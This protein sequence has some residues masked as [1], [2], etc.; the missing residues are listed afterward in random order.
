MD[1]DTIDINKIAPRDAKGRL[2]PGAQLG[3][4]PKKTELVQLKSI[5]DNLFKIGPKAINQL[6]ELLSHKNPNIQLGACKLVLQHLLPQ[7]VF[8]MSWKKII[9]EDSNTDTDIKR[10]M[11]LVQ[12]FLQFK[13]ARDVQEYEDSHKIVDIE[14]V[15]GNNLKTKSGNGGIKQIH[16]KEDQ[17]QN[18]DDT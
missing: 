3:T 9:K 14:P 12:E 4:L 18:H 2:L 11:G 7:Q 10:Q 8:S 5:K 17:H 15:S 1:R 13:S 16:P 6:N